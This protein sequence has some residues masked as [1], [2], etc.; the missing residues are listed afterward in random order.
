LGLALILPL[1]HD[2]PKILLSRL[3]VAARRLIRVK[4]V[5]MS[6][7]REVRERQDEVIEQLRKLQLDRAVAPPD[8]KEVIDAEIVEKNKEIKDLD[9]AISELINNGASNPY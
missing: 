8:R 4:G 9:A 2:L 6:R 7:I 5:P 1:P 3:R